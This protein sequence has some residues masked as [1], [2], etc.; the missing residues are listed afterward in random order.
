LGG[1]Q[2]EGRQAV[3][4]LLLAG[5]RKVTELLVVAGDRD[6]S[7]DDLERLAQELGVPVREVSRGKFD[8]ETRTESPQGVMARAAALAETDL[9]DLVSPAGGRP[10]FLV[11]LDGITDPGNLGAILRS[12]EGAGA[13]GVVLPRHRAVHVTP[14]A[15]KAA[16]GAVEY[17]P[18]A[19]VGGLPAALTDLK[20]RGVWVVGLDAAGD[21]SVHDLTLADEPVVLVVGSEGRGLSRLA[22]ERCD[23]LIHIPQHGRLASLNAGAAAAVACFEV[24]RRRSR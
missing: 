10:A 15:A 1:E 5:R 16:A 9:D 13:T 14:A 3:R 12:A 23:V 7:D 22:R 6:G 4:E 11:A 20:K 8:A 2:V 24:A 21:Q 18:M 17:L 19:V